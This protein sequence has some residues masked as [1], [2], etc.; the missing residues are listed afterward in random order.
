MEDSLELQQ[1][2][3][4]TSL[5]LFYLLQDWYERRFFGLWCGFHPAGRTALKKRLKLLASTA[6]PEVLCLFCLPLC[7][8]YLLPLFFSLFFSFLL[9]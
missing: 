6:K 3:P 8:F 1:P 4:K 2:Q 9:R 5:R 7:F